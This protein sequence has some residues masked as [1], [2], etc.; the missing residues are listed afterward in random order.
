MATD[1]EHI[2]QLA[3]QL[4]QL[5]NGREIIAFRKRLTKEQAQAV[6]R[7]PLI[8]PVDRAAI[9]LAIQFQGEQRIR[10]NY[11]WSPD[12]GFGDSIIT[13]PEDLTRATETPAQDDRRT[14]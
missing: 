10:N 11:H 13:T 3:H 2:A 4:L 6:I 14:A 1:D 8:G 12:W 7:H 5:R 9:I